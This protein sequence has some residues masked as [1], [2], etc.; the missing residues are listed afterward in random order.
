MKFK[1]KPWNHQMEAYE[2]LKQNLESKKGFA[3]FMDMGTGKS[4]V[5]IDYINNIEEKKLIVILCPKTVATVWTR[6][7]GKHSIDNFKIFNLTGIT[8]SAKESMIKTIDFAKQISKAVII[9]NYESAYRE[10]F[11]SWSYKQAIDLIILDESHKVKAPNGKASKFCAKLA[12][13]HSRKTILLTGTPLPHSPQDIYAQFRAMNP[14]I[15]GTSVTRFRNKYSNQWGQY[16]SQRTW[17][18]E[19]E[20]TEKINNNSYQVKA[21]DALD[22]PEAIHENI[23]IIMPSKAKKL[24]KELEEEF[25][26]WLDDGVEITAANA[27][28]K[29]L[30]LQ[31]LTGGF[32]KSEDTLYKVHSEKI[33]AAVGIIESLKEPVVIFTKFRP[34]LDGLKAE[35]EK[36][37]YRVKELSG[38]CNELG[39]GATYPDEC[40]ILLVQIQAGG[41]GIDLTAARICIYYSIGFNR[42]DYEQSLA[43]VHR[44]GQEKKVIYYHLEVPK[45]IDTYIRKNL[46]AKG[47]MVKN[48]LRSFYEKT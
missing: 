42:G 17:F 27:L 7:F 16:Q 23:D 46:K 24:Y 30:R 34:E 15:F 37:N 8:K 20:Y 25:I 29:L 22:L 41:V 35:F 1:T 5:V 3:L 45:S 18:T 28:V 36:K 21:S 6:E 33:D 10:P 43:R 48:I 26:I 13:K 31:Q 39:A 40:D 32:I 11:K 2:K 9:L 14:E 4:K 38:R 12:Q 44:P 47:D 19:G